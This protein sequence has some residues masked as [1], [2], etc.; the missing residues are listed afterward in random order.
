MLLLLLLL[1]PSTTT[2]LLLAVARGPEALN[3]LAED[4]N[5]AIVSFVCV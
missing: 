3:M 1:V 2:L 4:P 5:I